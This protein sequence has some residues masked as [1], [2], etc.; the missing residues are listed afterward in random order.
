[1][2]E[3]LKNKKPIATFTYDPISLKFDLKTKDEAILRVSQAVPGIKSKYTPEY[4]ALVSYA[5]D[6][7]PGDPDYAFHFLT[8][9]ENLG[10][11]VRE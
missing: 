4:D 11:E 3:I 8:L 7:Q 5:I 1:M 10:Y 6:L 9:L 2:P